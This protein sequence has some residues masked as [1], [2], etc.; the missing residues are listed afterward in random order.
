[1]E[2]CL[3]FAQ[4]TDGCCRFREKL[5]LVYRATRMHARN[6]AT[7]ATIYK[8]SLLLLKKFGPNGGKEGAR[9]NLPPPSPPPQ[10]ALFSSGPSRFPRLTPSQ[11]LKLTHPGPYD[12]FLAGLL[13]GYF[14]F[15]RPSPSGR[16]PSVNQ[17]IVIYVF[18][19]VVLALARIAVTPGAGLP[20]VSREDTSTRIRGVAWPAFASLSWATVMYLFR[21]YPGDLQS[22]LRSSMD[23][24]YLD[25]NEWDS[26]RNFF[27]HNK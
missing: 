26:L 7:F 22:S 6:L 23:Y 14:V 17:Q 3:G 2:R 10:P 1:M 20:I 15:G 8:L 12:T 11:T 13:G 18:A 25:S 24:I 5:R 16:I 4:G 9:R 19:R 27:W 21:W